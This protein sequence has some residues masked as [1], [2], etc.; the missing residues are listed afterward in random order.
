MMRQ[1]EE[2]YV[3]KTNMLHT[4]R[5]RRDEV[6]EPRSVAYKSVQTVNV[7]LLVVP[8]PSPSP[9]YF[10]PTP[11]QKKTLCFGPFPR[12]LSPP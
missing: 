9:D 11:T 10:L 5:Q 8:P 1:E 3:A 4:V 12:P 6:E 7:V 2:A